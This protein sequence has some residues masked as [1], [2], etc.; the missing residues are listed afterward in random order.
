MGIF[1]AYYWLLMLAICRTLRALGLAIVS[2]WLADYCD[3]KL[4]IARLLQND[5]DA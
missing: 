1:E 2:E 4:Q 5:L 3:L